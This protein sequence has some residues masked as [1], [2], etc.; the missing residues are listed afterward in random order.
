MPK[1]DRLQ[2]SV[3]AYDEGGPAEVFWA[4]SRDIISTDH[5]GSFM[6]HGNGW[7]TFKCWGGEPEMPF[8]LYI[9]GNRIVVT[10]SEDIDVEGLASGAEHVTDTIIFDSAAPNL[11]RT[12][13]L[14]SYEQV[15]AIARDL[16]DT[17]ENA[18]YT[19]GVAELIGD[20]FGIPGLGLGDRAETV[21]RELLARP[22]ADEHPAERTVKFFPRPPED[23]AEPG[24]RYVVDVI[25]D[26]TKDEDGLPRTEH[27]CGD[28]PE[29]AWK[30]A[31]A[32]A[33]AFMYEQEVPATG[34]PEN[35]IDHVH[36]G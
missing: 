14:P 32:I 10:M 29:H 20:C 19:R 36:A 26:W 27:G 28:T 5:E 18:E 16:V 17:G 1:N 24:F 9:A 21:T 2:V 6:L 30:V 3:V 12:G 4:R 35:K 25:M 13:E 34:W 7:A 23:H 22:V 8:V 15:I 31:R 33:A 11:G